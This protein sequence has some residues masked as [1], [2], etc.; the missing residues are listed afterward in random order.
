MKYKATALLCEQ[1]KLNEKSVSLDLD[2]S[3]GEFKT[4][5][6]AEIKAKDVS[7]IIM[8]LNPLS[9]K[10]FPSNSNEK[11]YYVEDKDI[12]YK[13]MKPEREA[14]LGRPLDVS[15]KKDADIAIEALTTLDTNYMISVEDFELYECNLNELKGYFKEGYMFQ[16][17]AYGIKEI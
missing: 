14:Q 3:F 9:I 11:P 16:N 15:I 7:G 10:V 4:K 5:E 12:I 8:S 1:I 2:I 13:T 6:E 17:V